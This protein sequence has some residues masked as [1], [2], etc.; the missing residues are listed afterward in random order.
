MG[1]ELVPEKGAI[2]LLVPTA[3]LADRRQYENELCH[4]GF[5]L[6]LQNRRLHVHDGLFI[7]NSDDLI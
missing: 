3:C 7:F 2:S 1:A 4:C 5:G 6:L